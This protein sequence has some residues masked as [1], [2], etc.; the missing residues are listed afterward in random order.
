MCRSAPH[1]ADA[2]ARF[3]PFRSCFSTWSRKRNENRSFELTCTQLTMVAFARLFVCSPVSISHIAGKSLA[4]IAAQQL[5]GMHTINIVHTTHYDTQYARKEAKKARARFAVAMVKV[6]N[7][8]RAQVL[9]LGSIAIC[10]FWIVSSTLSS[11]S[12]SSS[13]FCAFVSGPLRLFLWPLLVSL[14]LQS[15]VQTFA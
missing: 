14:W 12:S 11:S 2:C 7:I 15:L 4:R 9:W 10:G 6:V 8:L 5:R 13:C 3:S 1:L